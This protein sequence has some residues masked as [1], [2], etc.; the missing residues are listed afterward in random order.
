MSL[1]S[2][3]CIYLQTNKDC[4]IRVAVV[5]NPLFKKLGDKI[6]TIVDNGGKLKKSIRRKTAGR[7]Q[8][9]IKVAACDIS[10]WKLNDD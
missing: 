8:V 9:G 4:T 3:G 1:K 2:D 10:L 6:S 5:L 7:G